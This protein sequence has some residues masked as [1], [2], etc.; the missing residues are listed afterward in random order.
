MVKLVAPCGHTIPPLLTIS[1]CIVSGCHMVS[2]KG[3]QMIER[4]R[5]RER[6]AVNVA[7]LHTGM[8]P[9]THNCYLHLMTLYV[10]GASGGV[11]VCSS[12]CLITLYSI[13]SIDFR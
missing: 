13:H 10:V 6:G 5:E 9:N 8:R 4:E 7:T 3:S 11:C 2:D 1:C 12:R